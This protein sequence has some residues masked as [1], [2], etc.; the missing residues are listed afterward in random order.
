MN[1]GVNVEKRAKRVGLIGLGVMGSWM[2]K[3]LLKAG[4]SMTVTDIN[5]PRVEEMVSLGAKEA[6]NAAEVAKASDVVLIM[7][8][9]APEVLEVVTGPHGLIED[10]RPG[11]IVVDM[12]STTPIAAKQ[13]S[14]ILGK[15][16]VETLDAPVS[17]GEIG[18][19]DGTLSIMVGG[20]KKV[21]D[22]CTPIFQAIGKQIT[23]MGEAG[24]GQ[25][26]K[27]ATKLYVL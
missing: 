25:A 17:G 23:Y 8:P 12:S 22:E 16:S 11:L 9:D 4:Y 27:L 5:R 1:K 19:R 6:S 18:A 21:C 10:A 20:S 14:E 2:C 24:S 3:N 26:T 7:V 15:K 13:I